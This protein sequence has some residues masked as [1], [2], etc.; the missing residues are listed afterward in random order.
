[1]KYWLYTLN[2]FNVIC[3]RENGSSRGQNI[4]L[5]FFGVFFEDFTF[6][7]LSTE[8]SESDSKSNLD[9]KH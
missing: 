8:L 9:M 4:G 7:P 1:R 2:L 3:G 6:S 5:D